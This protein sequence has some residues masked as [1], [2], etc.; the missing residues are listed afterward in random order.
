MSSTGWGAVGRPTSDGAAAGV[1]AA[2]WCRSVGA[3]W[4]LELR[5][6]NGGSAP[7]AIV[8]WITSGVP[9]SHPEPPEALARELLAERG[10]Q[11]FSD[12]SAGPGTHNR[13]GIGYVCRNVELIRL[14]HLVRQGA[15]ETGVHPVMLA[16]QWVMAGFSA[17]AAA[18][19]IRKGVHSPQVAQQTARS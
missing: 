14:A 16:T 7:G 11:L 17:D 19:W 2:V 18:G 10:L 12:S 5:E 8:E 9:I 1:L 13:R 6:L 4:T 3:S 15:A